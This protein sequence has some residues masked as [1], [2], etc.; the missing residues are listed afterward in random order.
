VFAGGAELSIGCHAAVVGRLHIFRLLSK[1][2]HG[3]IAE[4]PV[5]WGERDGLYV[6]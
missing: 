3:G 4:E 1:F 6:G 2:S 5:R